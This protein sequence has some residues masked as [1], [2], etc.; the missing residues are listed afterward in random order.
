MSRA[1]WLCA[2]LNKCMVSCL[3]GML[4]AATAAH[5]AKSY[6]PG[7]DDSE[8]K[9]GQTMPY[10]GPA[11]AYASVGLAEAAYFRMLNERGGINARKI[12]LI[13]LDD[14]YSPPRT[15]EQTRRLVEDEQVLAIVG[16]LGTA[17]NSAIQK[18]L[19]QRK[20]PHVFLSTGATKWGDPQH[21]PWTMG[22]QPNYQLEGRIFA[23][24]T[25]RVAPGGRIAI[26]Y[27]NDDYGKDYL[28]GFRSGLG[29]AADKLI[30]LQTSYEIT[31]PTVDSQV[32]TLQASG[33]TVFFDVTTPKFAAQTIR[34]MYDIGWR[35][36]HLLNS[37]GSSTGAVMKPA[38]LERGQNIISAHYSKDAT[39]PRWAD[40]KGMK[41]Y[42]AFMKRYLPNIDTADSGTYAGYNIAHTIEYVLRQCGDNLTRENFMKAAANIRD[43]ELPM[44]LPG[45]RVNTSPANFFPVNQMQL[46]RFEGDGWVLFGD[47]QDGT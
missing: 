5:A 6:G 21:F 35:P 46:V 20:V 29:E 43:L 26:L 12:N 4:V 18:Y 8:I 13:S 2:S 33:A 42:L 30:A 36:L 47:V 15:V 28:K 41:E 38:G 3:A 45:I 34:K 40:D 9:L 37:V 22:W 11:S 44:L 1:K 19:N 39:D 31:D 17:A 16:S 7:V 14:G 23:Q 24:Y 10:S 32:V 27:Q 25:S